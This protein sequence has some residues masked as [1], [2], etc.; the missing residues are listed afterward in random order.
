MEARDES[1]REV[2]RLR[3][4]EEAIENGLFHMIRLANA[5]TKLK[6][7]FLVHGEESQCYALSEGLRDL[8]ITNVI[9]PQPGERIDI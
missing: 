5:N 4:G 7:V 6:G 9:A 8:G 1:K 3:E 2:R